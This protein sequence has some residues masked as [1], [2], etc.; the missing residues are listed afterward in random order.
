[1]MIILAV[2][3]INF[4]TASIIIIT[5]LIVM[6]FNNIGLFNNLHNMSSMAL[7]FETLNFIFN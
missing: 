7:G 1:M 5:I 2:I 3:I 6:L 4:I